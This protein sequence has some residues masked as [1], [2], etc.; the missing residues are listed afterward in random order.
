MKTLLN[1][2]ALI[3]VLFTGV[4]A[5]QKTVNEA[6]KTLISQLENPT[7]TGLEALSHPQLTYGHSNGRIENQKEFME[8]LV[9]GK[10]D[11]VTIKTSEV[12]IHEVGSTATLRHILEAD[13]NDGGVANHIR[14]KVLL[15]WVKVNGQWKLLARQAV[16]LNP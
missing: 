14:L 4:N 11:F 9:S 3:L 1:T 7:Q 6:F 16:K 8:A 12:E 2:L 13:I 15:V 5:Q 10:S